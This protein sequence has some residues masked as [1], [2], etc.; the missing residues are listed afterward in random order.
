[1]A[2]FYDL[3][4]R[5]LEISTSHCLADDDIVQTATCVIQSLLLI[6]L[7]HILLTLAVL[8][9]DTIIQRLGPLF[10]SLVLDTCVGLEARC[11]DLNL[12]WIAW[13]LN[14]FS[15]IFT[16]ADDRKQQKELIKEKKS[17]LSKYDAHERRYDYLV[18]T[19]HHLETQAALEILT[20]AQI[21]ATCN[22]AFELSAFR[23]AVTDTVSE[24]RRLGFHRRN[25]AWI[26]ADRRADDPI[27]RTA[28]LCMRLGGCCAYDCGCC[29]NVRDVVSL[30]GTM[31]WHCTDQ[32]RCCDRRQQKM[33]W[34]NIEREKSARFDSVSRWE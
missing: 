21:Q 1:M 6:I 33:V 14:I 23:Y 2:I 9:I 13:L 12:T 10:L 5:G 15:K 26:R 34:S 28:G 27:R 16:T 3:T 30:G 4:S 18:Q 24:F 22:L 32:C 8:L 31:L 19:L 29:H 11:D 17:V 7:I 20:V 25:G